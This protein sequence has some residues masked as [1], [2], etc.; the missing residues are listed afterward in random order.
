[1]GGR[2]PQFCSTNSFFSRN[3]QH[4]LDKNNG[5]DTNSI[6]QTKEIGHC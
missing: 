3:F 2:M 5:K 4:I 1:M 6:K